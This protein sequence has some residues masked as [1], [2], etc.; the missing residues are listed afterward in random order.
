M[1]WRELRRVFVRPG[2]FAVRP[3]FCLRSAGA[4]PA[5]L[6]GEPEG[7]RFD[8][9]NYYLCFFVGMV[10]LFDAERSLGQ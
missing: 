6:R 10:F 7:S 1:A 8:A 4:V 5:A 2:A 9:C 3:G